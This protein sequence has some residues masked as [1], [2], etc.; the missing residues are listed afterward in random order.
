[1]KI[2]DNFTDSK[3]L[4][5]FSS[6]IIGSLGGIGSVL[7]QLFVANRLET[8]VHKRPLLRVAI[9]IRAL[10]WGV[11]SLLT[12]LFAIS[13]PNLVLL[14]LFLLLTVFTL[15]GGVAVTPFM[16]I[17]GKA[18]PSTLRGRFFGYRQLLGGILAIASGF[19]AKYVLANKNF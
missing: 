6:T 16:D 7:P 9:T 18:I 19:I 15:M 14:S 13:H 11:L 4:I 2:S 8:K 1:M 5:G 10:C 17:W 3:I 12:Y